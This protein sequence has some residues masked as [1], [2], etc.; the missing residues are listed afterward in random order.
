MGI[1]TVVGVAQPDTTVPGTL[2]PLT[3]GEVGDTTRGTSLERYSLAIIG[4]VSDGDTLGSVGLPCE[5]LAA[6]GGGW[7][8][9]GGSGCSRGGRGSGSGRRG[10][11]TSITDVP[12]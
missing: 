12:N 9:D 5:L 3:N 4:R 7:G 10:R 6:E 2:E 11:A 8:S 1:E